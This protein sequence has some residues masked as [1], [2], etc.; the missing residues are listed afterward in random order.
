M[1]DTQ[2]GRDPRSE[3]TKGLASAD[4]ETRV[5]V[6]RAGGYA[7]HRERGLQAASPET[8]ERVARMGGAASHGGHATTTAEHAPSLSPA[9]SGLDLGPLDRDRL[10]ARSRKRSSGN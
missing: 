2:K 1:S 10:A 3:S 9:P 5:R 6:A 7:P 8:R 4:P